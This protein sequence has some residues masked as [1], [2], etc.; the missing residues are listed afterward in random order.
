GKALCS[1]CHTVN[2]MM[3]RQNNAVVFSNFTYHN[4]GVPKNTEFP[5]D[6]QPVDQVDNG[7]GAAVGNA[8]Y[9]GMFKTPHLRNID[10][11]APY[12]HNG[13]LKSLKEVVHFYNTRDVAGL[14]PAP[15]VS[16]NLETRL[17]GDLGLTDAEEDAIVAFMKTLTDR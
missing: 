8:N 12:M 3:M 4:I 13:F 9:N 17:V 7:L 6:Q 14:W 2:N 16:S 15:E 10:K 5:F 1:Q 11:T